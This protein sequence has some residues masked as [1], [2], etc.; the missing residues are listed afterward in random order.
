MVWVKDNNSYKD[1]K[2]INIINIKIIIQI[3]IINI[4]LYDG[5]VGA[6]IFRVRG[7]LANAILIF[8]TIELCKDF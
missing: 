5:F 4:R 6:I 1:N 7:L 8:V 2:H 3:K